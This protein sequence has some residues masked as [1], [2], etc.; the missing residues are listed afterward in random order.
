LQ[1]EFDGW[2]DADKKYA[3]AYE[4]NLTN[5]IKDIRTKTSTPD[6]PVIIPM[7]YLGGM[8]KLAATIRTAEVAVTKKL[9]NCDTTETKDYKLTDGAHYDAAGMVKIGT[10]CAQ[11]W[12]AMKYLDVVVPVINAPGKNISIALPISKNVTSYDL[13]G[14]KIV[15]LPVGI[16]DNTAERSIHMIINV[17]GNKAEKVL[18]INLR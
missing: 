5:L 17:N 3:D 13:T 10:I 7:I 18:P 8:W 2:Q 6:L 12:L 14:R 4:T 11:R 9:E 1:G 15:Q 16:L